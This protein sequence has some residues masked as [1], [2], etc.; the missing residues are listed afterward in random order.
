MYGDLAASTRVRFLQYFDSLNKGGISLDTNVLLPNEYLK[1]KFWKGNFPLQKIV[2]NF[3]IRI[4]VL[5]H[6]YKYD[7][8][9]VY[10]ELFPLV[11]AWVETKILSIPYIYDIDDAFHEKYQ[12]S[13]LHYL[14]NKIIALIKASSYV[15]AGNKILERQYSKINSNTLHVPS[16]AQK[17]HY[18]SKKSYVRSRKLVICWIGSPSTSKYL[19]NIIS[20]LIKAGKKMSIQ[21]IIIGGKMPNLPYI[22][23]IELPWTGHIEK[24]ILAKCDLGIMPLD[25]GEWEKGKCGYK[26]IQY[27]TVGLPVM[28][29]K[30]G[31]NIDICGKSSLSLCNSAGDWLTIFEKIY[32]HYSF[33]KM[34][35]L[36][37]K[38]RIADKYNYR[39]NISKIRSVIHKI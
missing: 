24:H 23:K 17:K 27:G 26:I 34:L 36:Q 30:I 39:Q 7:F 4:K 14:Q 20:P 9:I 16:V 25:S 13:K 38:S 15:F 8:A 35:A 37:L 10:S 21:L 11:P 18:K 19:A 3:F 2:S 29:S 32:N 1:W 5:M 6:L 22:E 31:A 12:N 28:A 33:R